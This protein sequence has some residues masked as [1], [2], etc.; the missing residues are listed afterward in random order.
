MR[1]ADRL[2]DDDLKVTLTDGHA[3]EVDTNDIAFRF[4][5]ADA[6]NKALREA[7]PVLL[8]PVMKLEVVTPE[9]YL[10]DV[11]ADLTGRRGEISATQPRPAEGDRGPG[12]PGKDV[13]LLH[14]R[15]EPQPGRQLLDGTP[16]VRPGPG[17]HA[18]EPRRGVEPGTLAQKARRALRARRRTGGSVG[19]SGAISR[20]AGRGSQVATPRATEGADLR[21]SR[22]AYL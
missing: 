18:G 4:A 17:Q 12:P 6:L 7:G 2:P 22:L 5:S 21:S 19:G 8:E 14:R 10:G 3:H 11:I 20:P 9:E 1:G 13:R 16:G 15:P